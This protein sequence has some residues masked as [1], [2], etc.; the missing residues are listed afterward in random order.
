MENW[1]NRSS[2]SGLFT[3]ATFP[4]NI[5]HLLSSSVLINYLIIIICDKNC[6][7]N[8]RSSQVLQGKRS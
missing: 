3:N 2:F 7:K 6:V 5:P 8:V 4:K 1:A